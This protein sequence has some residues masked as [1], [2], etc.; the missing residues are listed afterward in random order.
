MIQFK[1][2]VYVFTDCVVVEN[3]TIILKQQEFEKKDPVSYFVESPDYRPF[4]YDSQGTHRIHME[5]LRG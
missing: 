3:V 1:S 5:A 2:T 4:F